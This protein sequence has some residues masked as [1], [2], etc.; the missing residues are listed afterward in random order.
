MPKHASSLRPRAP[1][2]SLLF[3]FLLGCVILATIV[4]VMEGVA[5]LLISRPHLPHLP[6][7]FERGPYRSATLA[8]T[9]RGVAAPVRNSTNRWGLRG[10]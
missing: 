10:D 5:R 7:V 1:A 8:K 3:A 6:T 4:A 9:P 2:R